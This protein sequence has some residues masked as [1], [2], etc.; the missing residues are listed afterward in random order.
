M[1]IEIGALRA[2]LS[3]DS[4]A[5][6]KGAKQATTSMGRLQQR[7]KRISRNMSKIGKKMSTRLTAPIVAGV[8]LVL[9]SSLSTIDAQS[10]LA[11]SLGTSTRSMQ[12]LA[13]AADRAGLST[14][15]VGQITQQLTKRLSQA[16]AGG[17]PAAKT[18]K[19]LGLSAKD[20]SKLDLDQKL[21][22]INEAIAEQIPEA[23]RAAVAATIF[24]DRAGLLASRL[25]AATIRAAAS[26]IERFGLAVTEVEAD[27]IEEANDAIS[28]I[29]LVTKGLGNQ[30]AVA[31]APTLI[32]IAETIADL[33]T[34][35]AALS[36][37]MKKIVGI[38]AALAAGLGPLAITLGFLVAGLAALA[39]PIGLVVVGLSALAGAAAYVALNWSDLTTKYPA[40]KTAFEGVKAVAELLWDVFKV[41]GKA[42]FEVLK[43]TGEAVAALFNGDLHGAF[44]AIQSIGTNVF[45]YFQYTFPTFLDKLTGLI[46]S[47]KTKGQAIVQAIADG[48]TGFFSAIGSA[49]VALKDRI[50][51]ELAAIPGKVVDK[52]KQIG[53][54]IINGIKV[55]IG[56]G[57]GELEVATGSAVRK[58]TRAA[59]D[60]AEIKSP[61]RVFMR[62]GQQMMEGARIGVDKSAGGLAA[63]AASAANAAASAFGKSGAIEGAD[64]LR[65]SIDSIADAMAG[66]I[67]SGQNLGEALGQVFRQIAAD[68]LSSGIRDA[69]GTLIGAIG[70]TALAPKS[71][72]RPPSRPVRSFDGGGYTW[73]GPRVGGLDGKGGRLAMLHPRETVIDH[74]RGGGFGAGVTVNQ[75]INISTGVA[76][77]VRAEIKTLMPKIAENTVAA[78]VEAKRRGGHVGRN[79]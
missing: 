75:S 64:R 56:L 53:R 27:K 2:L 15:E 58:A 11:Q 34:R 24:G 48:I 71:S 41:S 72:P 74:T 39:S 29:G 65:N 60:E 9:R 76:Q 63:S 33:G 78:V 45:A 4:A 69:I 52:A 8:G 10:K 38:G 37:R 68:Y 13:R 26:E 3:L 36:P 66:A 35:F 20:L 5:F 32:K 42:A 54:D 70:G 49:F 55:G 21:L 17:G 1:A 47:A 23:E 18:L 12:V 62:I 43:G 6:E 61:S 30:L 22:A 44:K 28:A 77:T 31:L 57:E 40:L 50:L 51:E 79:L 46:E 14:G 19:R 25:D 67:T 7:L 16:A 59:E 73:D